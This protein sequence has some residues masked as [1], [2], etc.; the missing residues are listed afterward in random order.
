MPLLRRVLNQIKQELKE[1]DKIHEEGQACM[2]QTISLSKQAILQ[3]HQKK[4]KKAEKLIQEASENIK[5]LQETSNK[6]PEMIF[7]G[8]YS[9]TLQEY[10]EANILLNLI[11]RNEFITPREIHVLPADFILG[12]A[13]VI[14][15]YRRLALDYLREG[16]V[17]E[18]E[19]CL[20]IMDDIFIEL[21]SLDETYMLVPGLRRK[22]DVARKVIEI[23][24]GDVT[25]EV[26]RS[27]L[28]GYLKRFEQRNKKTK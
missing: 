1:K 2:R 20:Q 27:A 16:N 10:S 3:I 4:M 13:D 6:H 19:E 8:F 11:R 15:E 28:E 23:T 5:R 14:G 18:S 9:A 26:R 25:Q 22:N 7:G 17:K 21:L 12:L 24:R